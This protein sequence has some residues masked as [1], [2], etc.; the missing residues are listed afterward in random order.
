M[1][2]KPVLGWVYK[3]LSCQF[4]INICK[5][6]GLMYRCHVNKT[7]PTYLPT[8]IN[9]SRYKDG[10]LFSLICHAF[11]RHWY[12]VRT[13]SLSYWWLNIICSAC[14]AI[15]SCWKRSFRHSTDP[16][17]TSCDVTVCFRTL[18]SK[19]V[20]WHHVMLARDLVRVKDL[21]WQCGQ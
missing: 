16:L 13:D 5:M 10:L 19:N 9:Q 3:V 15:P 17:Q 18:S 4:L 11:A 20:L 1:T 14:Q 12:Q 8:Y 7:L 6:Q 2:Y 21:V